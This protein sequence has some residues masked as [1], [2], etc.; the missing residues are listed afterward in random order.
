MNAI[1][2][3]VQIDT[4]LEWCGRIFGIVGVIFLFV[5][6]IGSLR[7]RSNTKLTILSL[8]FLSISVIGYLLT[9][10]ILR[11]K[12]LP[13]IF[14]LLWIVFLWAYLICNLISAVSISKRTR[15]AKKAETEENREEV[16]S[17]SEHEQVENVSEAVE[18][19]RTTK[20]KKRSGK[21]GKSDG[22]E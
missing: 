5:E 14:S 17:P 7:K 4:I 10:L 18:E 2:G 22:K 16:S 20:N 15:S 8:V 11:N 9:D 21:K 19:Q 13:V 6:A 3:E 12:N 1:L